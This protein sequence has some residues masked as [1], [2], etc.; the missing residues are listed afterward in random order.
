[1]KLNFSN[2]KSLL[3][4]KNTYTGLFLAILISLLS[5]PL[6]VFF[7]YVSEAVL[8]PSFFSLLPAMIAVFVFPI[9]IPAL[10]GLKVLKRKIF[11]VIILFVAFNL[12]PIGSEITD[13]IQQLQMEQR[14]RIHDEVE[15]ARKDIKENS[16]KI[17]EYSWEV[18]GGKLIGKVKINFLHGG[19]YKYWLTS[20]TVIGTDINLTDP[21]EIRVEKGI[22]EL[23]ATFSPADYNQ[24]SIIAHGALVG[25]K[26]PL[27]CIHLYSYL[28]EKY[29]SPDYF[30]YSPRD[31]EVSIFVGNA[32]FKEK[33]ECGDLTGATQAMKNYKK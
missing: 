10:V 4:T 21:Q 33:N 12:S 32:Y 30:I 11:A 13:Q 26:T 29:R 31:W 17:K 23:E 25:S 28:P 7:E 24:A 6:T 14:Q 5:I 16:A 1:M 2:L 8:P 22:L 19:V 9:L 18:M 27:L 3:K 15:N 20:K